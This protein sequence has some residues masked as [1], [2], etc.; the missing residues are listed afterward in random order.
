M[1]SISK[2]KTFY[3]YSLYISAVYS[4]K[5]N[6]YDLHNIVTN[7]TIANIIYLLTTA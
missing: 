5:N 1:D 7:L 6:N 4:Y 3:I 2:S